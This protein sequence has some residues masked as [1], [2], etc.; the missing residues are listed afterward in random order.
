MCK[1]CVNVRV[2]GML[3]ISVLRECCIYMYVLCVL[4]ICVYVTCA[5]Y[6]QM[7]LKSCVQVVCSVCLLRACSI[8]VCVCVSA[9]EQLCRLEMRVC[10]HH[11]V[12]LCFT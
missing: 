7:G 5:A 3:F 6:R 8:Y 4:H 11:D 9:S 2:C 12:Y 1:M 10:M